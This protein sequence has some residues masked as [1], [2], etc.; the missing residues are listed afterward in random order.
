MRLRCVLCWKIISTEVPAST[1]VRA[2]A[3]CPECVEKFVNMILGERAEE[4]IDAN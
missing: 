3:I 1:I 4:E 2:V